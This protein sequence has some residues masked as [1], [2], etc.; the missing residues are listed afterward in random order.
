MVLEINKAMMYLK[1]R[2][3]FTITKKKRKNT[4]N[5]PELGGMTLLALGITKHTFLNSAAR[6]CL[7]VCMEVL[8]IPSRP[9]HL[10]NPNLCIFPLEWKDKL[11]TSKQINPHYHVINISLSPQTEQFVHKYDAVCLKLHGKNT[12]RGKQR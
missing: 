1:I 5:V 11:I 2:S 3:S 7:H 4:P 12:M 9:R 10:I 6:S 8:Q